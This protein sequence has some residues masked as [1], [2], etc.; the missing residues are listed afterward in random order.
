MGDCATDDP[1]SSRRA[2][3]GFRSRVEAVVAAVP[4]GTVVSYGEV[5][6]RAGR[7]GAAR[8]VGNVLAA[9]TGLPWWRVVRVDGRL[10]ATDPADQACRLRREGVSVGAG[11]LTDPD[12]RASLRPDLLGTP[13]G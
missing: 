12:R 3:P 1:A 10:A 7:P 8:A 6:A 9:S 11:R 5:A 2:S 4:P 13:A